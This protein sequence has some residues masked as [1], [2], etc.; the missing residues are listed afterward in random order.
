[1]NSIKPTPKMLAGLL[2]FRQNEPVGLFGKDAPS[3]I[4][5]KRLQTAGWIMP[6]ERL[7]KTG[8]VEYQ[9]TEKGVDIL[10]PR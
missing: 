10:A 4:I 9:V 3:Y 6:I 1:M 5:R 7:G 2:W 8:F